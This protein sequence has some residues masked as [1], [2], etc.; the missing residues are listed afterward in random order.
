LIVAGLFLESTVSVFQRH[1]DTIYNEVDENP[2][3][4]DFANIL[5]VHTRKYQN[6]V[7]ANR[8][9]PALAISKAIDPL[10]A[11]TA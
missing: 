5:A 2:L 10:Q 3:A 9:P 6:L 7:G 4:R 1:A 8:W 11:M